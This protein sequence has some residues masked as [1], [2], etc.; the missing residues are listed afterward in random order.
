MEGRF[1]ECQMSNQP[2][3]AKKCEVAISRGKSLPPKQLLAQIC[4]ILEK[5]GFMD[6]DWNY[7][8]DG[9]FEEYD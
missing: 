7:E 4:T 2:E 3:W 1:W 9:Y 8:S 6:T 5:Y